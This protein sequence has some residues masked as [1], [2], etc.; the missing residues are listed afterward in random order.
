MVSCDICGKEFKNTQGLRGHKNFVHN[1][2]VISVGPPV[3]QQ[4]TQQLLSSKLSVPVTTEQRLSQLEDRFEKLEHITG[5]GKTG[6]RDKMPSITD[7]S[8]TEQVT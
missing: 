5:V 3:A 4:S 2:K 6:E 1:D 7:M 8:L